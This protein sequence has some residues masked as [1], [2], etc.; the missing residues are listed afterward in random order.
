[1]AIFLSE[2]TILFRVFYYP[3]LYFLISNSKVHVHYKIPQIHPGSTKCKVSISK[4][5]W[6]PLRC[7][8]T[9]S[10]RANS[11]KPEE[12]IKRQVG[13]SSA[14]SQG[15]EMTVCLNKEDPRIPCFTIT[16]SNFL[17][18]LRSDSQPLIINPI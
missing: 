8:H 17:G 6:I 4:H 10:S 14:V 3:I 2:E 7:F 11:L 13:I 1:M 16:V 18:Q 5:I 9:P 12:L 15:R